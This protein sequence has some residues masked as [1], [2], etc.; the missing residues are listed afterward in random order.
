MNPHQ[1]PRASIREL[2][3]SLW[4]HRFLILQ[5]T[6]RDVIGRYR[7]SAMGLAW[8]FFYPVLMLTVYTFVFSVVFKARWGGIG[9]SDKASFAI[10]LFV[11]MIVHGLFA[12]CVNRAPG[13]ILSNVNYVKKVVFPLEILPS[14]AMGSALF[15]AGVSL[16]VLLAARLIVDQQLS[17]TAM[18][19]PLILLPLCLATMGAAW[20]LS[21]IGVYLRDVGQTVGIFTTALLFLSP[22]FYP[23]TA[24]PANYQKWL[25][26]NPLTFV[27]EESRKVLVSGQ[28]PDWSAW[29]SF[30]LVS[31]AAAWIGFWWFQKSRK[32][33]AD[34]L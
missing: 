28:L 4:R 5:L 20:F 25:R 23:L 34:V 18:F 3:A 24:L 26:L 14:V 1:A 22:V 8:S 16:L 13:L 2:F 10:F 11:G 9:D 17:W 31:L 15:H 19:I 32:G 7:G 6:K 27:I 21:A 33:F 12:E 30:F 29:M